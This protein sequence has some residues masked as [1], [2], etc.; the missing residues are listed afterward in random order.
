[1]FLCLLKIVICCEAPRTI[2][3]VALYQI[4]ILLLLLVD[5]RKT[6]YKLCVCVRDCMCVHVCWSDC[7]G[8][9]HI[10]VLEFFKM[11]NFYDYCNTKIK[12]YKSSG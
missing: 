9:C 10:G 11:S 4:N 8:E 5:K 6:H 12:V 7:M 3:D 1:M 2:M